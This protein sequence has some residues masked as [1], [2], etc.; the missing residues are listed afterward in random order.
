MALTLGYEPIEIRVCALVISMKPNRSSVAVA[1]VLF[2]LLAPPAH[3]STLQN[4]TTLD[5]TF[6]NRS[7]GLDVIDLDRGSAKTLSLTDEDH[8]SK[9]CSSRSSE[10]GSG[11]GGGGLGRGASLSSEHSLAAA[12]LAG[13]G[14]GGGTPGRHSIEA[15][16]FGNDF[17]FGANL[18]QVDPASVSA[19]PLPGALPLFASGLGALGLLG[20]WRKRKAAR[21]VG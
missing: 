21:A 9:K 6:G 4:G 20:W 12:L 13:G 1:W 3:A 19:A 10:G 15:F 7:S 16:N 11:G 18:A 2:L 8:C 17:N 5:K 14:S